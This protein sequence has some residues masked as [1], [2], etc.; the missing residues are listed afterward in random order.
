MSDQRS[1]EEMGGE[2]VPEEE[3][4]EGKG[5]DGV[6]PEGHDV[7]EEGIGPVHGL[8]ELL[9]IQQE[10]IYLRFVHKPTANRF[11]L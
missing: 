9:Y 1:E 10:F 2:A 3:D 5:Q 6:G 7:P 4:A 8:L 11:I